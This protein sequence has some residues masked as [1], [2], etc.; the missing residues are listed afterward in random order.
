MSSDYDRGQDQKGLAIL[1]VLRPFKFNSFNH[2]LIC[3][4]VVGTAMK[5]ASRNNPIDV[6]KHGTG[7]DCG[8]LE[9]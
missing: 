5:R 8:S 3:F 1:E 7:R 6:N 9:E 2:F 4:V